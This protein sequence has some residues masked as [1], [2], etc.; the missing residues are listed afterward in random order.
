MSR[1]YIVT[2]DGV[3]KDY[4]TEIFL[5]GVYDSEEEAKKGLIRCKSQFRTMKEANARVSITEVEMNET[6]PVA[7]AEGL[8]FTE[9]YL[10]GYIE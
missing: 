8:Y 5:G 6:L 9:E 1:A 7:Y 10:G 4:G 3:V 2:F